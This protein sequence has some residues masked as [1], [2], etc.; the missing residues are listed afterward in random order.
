MSHVFLLFGASRGIG[1]A[2]AQA[3]TRR[4]AQVCIAARDG[5]QLATTKDEVGPNCWTQVTDIA[6]AAGV[7]ATVDA[8]V[9][10]F[11]RVDTVINFA[12]LT[13]PM[14]RP[15]WEV[16]PD[17]TAAVLAAN[18]AGPAHIAR[19]CVPRMLDQGQGALLFA[20]SYFGDNMQAGMG[21]YGAS[22]AGAHMLV[23]Q[24]A[25]ELAGSHVGAALIYPG[26]TATDGLKA[27][28]QARND[29]L[30][31]VQTE[32]PDRMAALFV[33][34]AMQAPWEIN[35][36]ALSWTNPDHRAAAL[37]VL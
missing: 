30:N 4:G 9:Q 31:N 28:R 34:A 5:A 17:E 33:W 1:A 29:A 27:F 2:C 25:A 26:V 6:D 11:G 15:L 14:D 7:E 16:Q 36:A 20:T 12:A 13:G 19:A 22:R 32:T 8:V 10:K 18:L 35:G 37:A 23:H 3:L 24:L 21:A